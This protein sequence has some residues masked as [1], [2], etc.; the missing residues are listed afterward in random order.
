MNTALRLSPIYDRLQQVPGIWQSINE[1]PVLVTAPQEA[2]SLKHLGI[3]DLSFLR[4][5]GVK[6][7]GAATWLADQGIQVSDRPNSWQALSGGGIVARLGLNE[8]LIEDSVQSQF[9][10]QLAIAA[11]SP[12]AKVY[13]VLR[14]DFTI[15]LT[16]KF[17][18]ELLR[19]TCNINFRALPLETQPVV[20]T[21]MIGISVIIIPG[22]RDGLPFYRVWGDGTF[23]AYVWQTLLTIVEELG[24][25]IVGAAQLI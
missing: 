11:Q 7:T 16:G 17:V 10:S 1:M 9:V 19:Q 20:L 6:G 12:P 4:R 18:D 25:G 22:E 15:A 21:S 24:G 3:A 8:F 14:Q 13:P 23:G 5:F 2:E